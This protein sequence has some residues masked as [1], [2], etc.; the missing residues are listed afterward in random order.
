MEASPSSA[1]YLLEPLID[2]IHGDVVLEDAC[3][4]KIGSALIHAHEGELKGLVMAPL[5]P[6]GL[7]K[8]IETYCVRSYLLEAPELLQKSEAVL[9]TL[10]KLAEVLNDT[11]VISDTRSVPVDSPNRDR[12]SVNAAA[13]ITDAPTPNALLASSGA[14]VTEVLEALSQ[15]CDSEHLTRLI[16]A[17]GDAVVGYM[18]HG[19]R[20][21][22]Q[23][24][25]DYLNGHTWNPQSACR[26]S[27]H[28]SLEHFAAS[29]VAQ[30]EA[31]Q[32]AREAEVHD[33]LFG[34]SSPPL[35]STEA[36]TAADFSAT[37]HAAMEDAPVA[38]EVHVQHQCLL[39]HPIPYRPRKGRALQSLHD[40]VHEQCIALVQTT[41]H[42]RMRSRKETDFG[43]AESNPNGTPITSSVSTADS[44]PDIVIEPSTLTVEMSAI[45]SPPEPPARKLQRVD[46]VLIGASE[47]SVLRMMENA[48]VSAEN[49]S[50]VSMSSSV[51]LRSQP[52]E[53]MGETPAP[54]SSPSLPASTVDAVWEGVQR[55]VRR[56]EAEARSY[57]LSRAA[58]RFE[59]YV[60]RGFF[61]E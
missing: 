18:M 12:D 43:T 14:A 29:A 19:S 56:H 1:T 58:N 7:Q 11:S 34:D 42:Q 59:P 32:R 40:S 51:P 2:L 36:G 8:A 15:Q 45:L 16:D 47:T 30:R 26:A 61:S 37:V 49:L 10:R 22:A 60:A 55:C 41:P 27:Y 54:P 9:Q 5:L 4:Q 33:I 52:Q 38:P 57:F 35:P 25:A 3:C 31:R 53:L 6:R 24:A 28:A 48:D 21:C 20:E 50:L 46:P 13:A 44:S 23:E 17:L 39:K